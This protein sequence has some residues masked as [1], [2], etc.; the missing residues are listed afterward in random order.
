M[1]RKVLVEIG[2]ETALIVIMKQVY[3]NFEFMSGDKWIKS[4][5]PIYFSTVFRES[6]K[7]SNKELAEYYP[8]WCPKCRWEGLSRDAEGGEQIANTD[9]FNEL[10]CP[11][12]LKADGIHTLVKEDTRQAEEEFYHGAL[13]DDEY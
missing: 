10:E 5:D 12:C 4:P 9:K 1:K 7:Y 2:D 6:Q 11:Y 8:V 3:K 13:Y